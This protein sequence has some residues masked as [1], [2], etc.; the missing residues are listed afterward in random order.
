MHLITCGGSYQ[1]SRVQVGG[2]ISEFIF[3]LQ[4]KTGRGPEFIYYRNRRAI[5]VESIVA[6]NVLSCF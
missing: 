5:A 2:I 1:N 6:T 4:N 3:R